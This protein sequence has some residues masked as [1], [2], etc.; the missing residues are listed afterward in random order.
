MVGLLGNPGVV[1]GWLSDSR[2]LLVHV[3]CWPIIEA[4][5]PG[6]AAPLLSVG[7]RVTVTQHAGAAHVGCVLAPAGAP[8]GD[9][10]GEAPGAAG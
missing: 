7:T 8:P 2:S 4:A 1:V 10:G 9:A 6:W 5:V 3:G